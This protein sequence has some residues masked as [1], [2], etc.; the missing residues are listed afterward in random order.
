[1]FH[2][3]SIRHIYKSYFAKS[4]HDRNKQ[5]I[6]VDWLTALQITRSLAWQVRIYHH[7]KSS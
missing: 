5:R 2:H 6:N 4:R 7:F 3:V 1:M